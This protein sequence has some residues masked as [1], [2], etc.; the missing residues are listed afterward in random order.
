MNQAAYAPEYQRRISIRSSEEQARAFADAF[1]HSR[2]VRFFKRAIIA[3]SS[4]ILLMLG[5]YTIFDPFSKLPKDVSIAKATLNGTR[6]TMERPRL[7]GFRKDG[8]PYQLRARSGIQDIRKP[9]IIELNEIE[10]NIKIDENDTMNVQAPAGVFDSSADT[11]Q[12]RGNAGE[13]YIRMKGANY[14][15]TL[16]SADVNFKAGTVHS[17]EPV[18]VQMNNGTILA[19]S[20]DVADNGKKIT[21]TGNVRTVLKAPPE[22]P[23]ETESPAGNAGG[24]EKGKQE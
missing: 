10:A 4:A 8:R 14:A 22:K 1:R 13:S 2:R 18:D 19:D 11:I 17:G 6:I 5:A 12:L 20:L 9:S 3:G 15:I 23:G 7:S 16:K 24:S 21:F